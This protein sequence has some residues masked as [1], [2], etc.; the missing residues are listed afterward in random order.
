MIIKAQELTV[1]SFAPYGSFI[2]PMNGYEGDETI[3]FTPDR[4]MYQVG[5]RI[6]SM[7][8]IRIKW[9]PMEF[10]VTEYHDEC[11][12]VFGGFGCEVVFH[13]GL[14]SRTN[15]PI[16]ESFA[17][18]RHPA[19]WYARVKR[20]VL[21]HAGFVVGKDDVAAGVVLLSPSAYTIDCHVIELEQPIGI[22]V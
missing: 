10:G 5:G 12:E 6:G 4:M 2:N 19:G 20:R 21:H 15:Q 16:P 18:F 11:E 22:E 3:E 13:V 7:S 9:R 17:V 8:S 1:E 14:V